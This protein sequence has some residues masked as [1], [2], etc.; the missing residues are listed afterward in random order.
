V[1]FYL[2]VVIGVVATALLFQALIKK[3]GRG[4]AIKPI[5]FRDGRLAVARR[6]LPHV[7][8]RGT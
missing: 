3:R 6:G 5:P 7:P 1:V 8:R 4:G 2:P